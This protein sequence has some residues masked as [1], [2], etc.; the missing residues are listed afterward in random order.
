MTRYF[1]RKV[2]LQLD[3]VSYED[4]RIQFSI[5]RTVSGEPNA[6]RISIWGLSRET[7][8]NMAFRSRDLRVRL[9]AGYQDGDQQPSLLFEGNPVDEGLVFERE[10]AERILRIQ[11]QDGIRRYQTA[12]VN[13]AFEAGTTYRQ[14]VEEVVR[15]MG[16]P[17]TTIQTDDP[18]FDEVVESGVCYASRAT[19]VLDSLA[20]TLRSDWS[21][22]DGKLQFIQKN[23]TRLERGPRFSPELNNII[24][25]PK[26]RDGGLDVTV[27]LTPMIPGDRF[28]VEG[29]ADPRWNGLFRAVSVQHRGDSGWA[30]EFYTT[31]EGRPL[32][33]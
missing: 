3:D 25:D 30:N 31:I 6:A 21:I 8:S 2:I 9:L 24:N 27:F 19:R 29:T 10:G 11:A 33:T 22:Q 7:A 18:A 14:I 17:Q 16:L 4:Y 26:P 12:R 20:Q 23:R 1:N 13:V 32:P 15:Q 5:T 28:I